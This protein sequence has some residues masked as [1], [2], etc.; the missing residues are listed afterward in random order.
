MKRLRASHEHLR[1]EYE[2]LLTNADLP[3][4]S[5]QHLR[6]RPADISSDACY[7]EHK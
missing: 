4:L 5:K 1:D 2:K 3:A 6:R 7:E